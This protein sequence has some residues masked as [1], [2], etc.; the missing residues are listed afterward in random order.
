M[1]ITPKAARRAEAECRIP[2]HGDAVLESI[3]D[4]R[5]M[6]RSVVSLRSNEGRYLLLGLAIA[7]VAAASVALTSSSEISQNYAWIDWITHTGTVL[8]T[9]DTARADSVE[10]LAALQNYSQNGDR[11]SL[12][13]VALSL[14]EV[15]R[16]A[17][18]LRILTQDNQTQ[19]QWLDQIDR[20]G[21]RA[22]SLARDVIRMAAT[23]SHLDVVKAASFLDLDAMLSRLRVEFNP[24]SAM[25][26]ALLIDRIA[27]ARATS[28][29]SA[30]MM[31]IGGGIIFAWL[32]LIG[33]YAGLTTSRLKQ[34]AHALV[35][36]Q[37]ELARVAE[38]KKADDRFRVL[39]ESAPDPIVILSRDGRIVLVNAQAKRSLATPVPSC[40][41]I[42][43]R[44]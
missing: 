30:M 8:G 4:A 18:G 33:G 37:E 14:S 41:A 9:L 16:Q 21:A 3:A 11:K 39:L 44:C 2:E 22:A 36:S 35:L 38:R 15:R 25:E 31:G 40:S 20:T 27:K 26:Q 34:T 6:K 23:I 1:D 32:L 29:R 7:I 28:R 24:M 19:Q 17:V 12:D 5:I 10:S 13:K 43:A 42:R